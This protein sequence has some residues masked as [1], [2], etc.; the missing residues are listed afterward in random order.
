MFC[1]VHDIHLALES[2]FGSDISTLG[3]ICGLFDL[4]KLGAFSKWLDFDLTLSL[5]DLPLLI[6]E[7]EML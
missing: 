4:I 3:I 1:R 7:L 2:R 6:K 5:M